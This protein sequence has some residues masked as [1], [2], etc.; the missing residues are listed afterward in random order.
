MPPA[1]EW[2]SLETL[3][4]AAHQFGYGAVFIGILLEN[5]GIPLP[6]ETITL[7]GG[8]LAG[9]GELNYWLVLATAIGGAIAGDNCGYWLGRWGGWSLLSRI[10]RWFR[11]PEERLQS[12][13]T[14]FLR[15][16]TQVVLF[17]R[18][19][20]F[21]RIFA[22]PLA[23]L[24]GMAYPRFLLCNVVGA[25]LWGSVMVSLAFF[26][27]QVVPLAQLMERMKQ[28]G[29]LAL[30]CGALWFGISHWWKNRRRRAALSSD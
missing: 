7:L 19:V 1:L 3:Q 8:F 17:G 25:T 9:S 11:I 30:A 13:Q 20:A 2:F 21:L 6:G 28:F 10:A 29:L 12:L 24:A 27:G 5:T 4:A 23:G 15:N 16:G 26:V 22:G 14:E 18:F